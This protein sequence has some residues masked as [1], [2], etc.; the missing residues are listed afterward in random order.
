MLR[1]NSQLTDYEEIFAYG[2]APEDFAMLTL[3]T[4]KI[5]RWD[6]APP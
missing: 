6:E 5:Y 4:T 1:L 3:A 2:D